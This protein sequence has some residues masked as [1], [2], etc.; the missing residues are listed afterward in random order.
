MPPIVTDVTVVAW[1]LFASVTPRDVY[2]YLPVA[3]VLLFYY[4]VRRVS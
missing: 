2:P 1:S 4:I 3:G